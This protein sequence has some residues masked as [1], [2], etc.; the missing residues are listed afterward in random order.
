MIV[1]VNG[2]PQFTAAR[3]TLIKIEHIVGYKS[4]L[5]KYHSIYVFPHINLKWNSLASLK[6]QLYQVMVFMEAVLQE[7]IFLKDVLL[8]TDNMWHLPGSCLVRGHI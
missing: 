8:R 1:V 4:N 7:D 5:L 2:L 3:F 6:T